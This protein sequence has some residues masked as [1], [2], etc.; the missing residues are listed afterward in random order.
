MNSKNILFSPSDSSYNLQPTTY[1]LPPIA[2]TIAG[3]DCS[4]GAGIQAD[5]KTFGAFGCYGLT[6]V[7]CVVAEVPGKVVS[8]QPIDLP[9]IRDQLETLLASFPIAAIKTGMLFSTSIIELIA[10]VLSALKNPPPLIIDPVMVASSGDPLLEPEALIAY[11]E[12][13]FPL[14]TLITPNLDELTLMTKSSSQLRSLKSMKEAGKKFLQE[15]HLPLLLKGGHL[16]SDIATDILLM[17]DGTEEAFTSEF[18]QDR[19]THGTGCTYSA[20]ITAGLARGASLNQAVSD[21]KKFITRAIA[22]GFQWE[23][24]AALNQTIR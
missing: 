10:E 12:K 15:L 19:E 16:Q 13:L 2:L 17:P 20:A 5:L 24:I 23:K 7:T 22:N 21:A 3:S 1:N 14:A 4:S 11:R 18:Y 8:I 6:V 9:I